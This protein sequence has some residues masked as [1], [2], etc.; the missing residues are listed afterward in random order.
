MNDA[1]AAG[2]HAAYVC[3]SWKNLILA[4]VTARANMNV[5]SLLHTPHL[6]D[7][8]RHTVTLAHSDTDTRTHTHIRTHA[9]AIY[10]GLSCINGSIDGRA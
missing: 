10:R 1:T 9:P 7:W 6:V 5:C 8:F 2:M 4:A 3:R